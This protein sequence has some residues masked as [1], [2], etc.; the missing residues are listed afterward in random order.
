VA[1]AFG[2]AVAESVRVGDGGRRVGVAVI[3][4][5]GDDAVVGEAMMM[6]SVPGVA[7]KG[8]AVG[9]ATVGGTAVAATVGAAVVG[10]G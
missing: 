8:T 3:V 2:K 10:D 9:G 7:V 1:L 6:C 4:A 5:G